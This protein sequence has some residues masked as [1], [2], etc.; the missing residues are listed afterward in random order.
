[1][2]EKILKALMQLFALIARPESN[3]DERRAVVESF[4]TKQLNKELVLSYLK[5]F[6]EYYHTY[7]EKQKS[8]TKKRRIIA[9]SSVKVLKIGTEINE[10][11]ALNQKI[12][13]LYQLLEFSSSEEGKI[14]GQELEFIES[15]VSTFNIDNT[16]FIDIRDFILH[17]FSKL[18]HR[19]NLLVIDHNSLMFGFSECF[20]GI[21]ATPVEFNRRADAIRTGAKNNCFFAPEGAIREA[22]SGLCRLLT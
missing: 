20:N 5:V 15:L 1:M 22:P 2:S 3:G 14:T 6:D 16:E 10:E 8:T 4:L 9:A 19:S 7:Q 11:L 17:P 13:V 12:S 18:P 21:Y